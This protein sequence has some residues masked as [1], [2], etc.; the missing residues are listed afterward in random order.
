V[1]EKEREG[2]KEGEKEEQRDSIT[3]RERE[4]ERE[5][6]STRVRARV[7]EKER[8]CVTFI[9][10]LT[11]LSRIYWCMFIFSGGVFNYCFSILVSRHLQ[12]LSSPSK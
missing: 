5:R 9:L 1:T 10:F 7:Q 12:H 11:V 3:Q 2:E 8:V 4:R 6:K